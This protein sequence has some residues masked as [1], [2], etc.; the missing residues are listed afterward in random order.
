MAKRGP[1]LNSI[2]D[3]SAFLARCTRETYTGA[4]EPALGGK[5]AYLSNVLIRS[6]EVGL[7]EKRIDELES[8][9]K[10]GKSAKL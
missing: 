7:L 6:M 4:L 2:A 9:L 3:V 5:I 10:V 8:S 1:R